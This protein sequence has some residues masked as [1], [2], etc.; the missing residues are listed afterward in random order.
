MSQPREG[1]GH[2]GKGLRLGRR[3]GGPNGERI[4]V[5]RQGLR[6]S[7]ALNIEDQARRP[8]PLLHLHK[9]IRAASQNLSQF[10]GSLGGRQ[11]RPERVQR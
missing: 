5:Y 2:E 11:P 9:Q 3:H 10:P 6:L 8:L 1:L 4:A 7:H